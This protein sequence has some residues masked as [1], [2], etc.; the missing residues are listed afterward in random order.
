MARILGTIA[1][2][3]AE[4]GT[5]FESIATVNGTGSSDTITFTSIPGTYQH[6]QI[7]CMAFGSVFNQ[8]GML[9]RINSDSGSNYAR[10]NLRGNGSSAFAGGAD[11]T[12]FIGLGTFSATLSDTFPMVAIVDIHDYADTSKNKTVRSFGGI[13]T[14]TNGGGEVSLQSGVR[15]NTSAITSISILTPG[16]NFTTNSIFALYGIKGA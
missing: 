9:L 3:F 7:R 11:S 15:L 10:H 14:N 2:S 12:T 8:N 4:A 1:S 16:Q 6:L 13:D 5:F